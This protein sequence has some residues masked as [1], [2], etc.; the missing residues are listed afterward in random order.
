MVNNIIVILIFVCLGVFFVCL[1]L[2]LIIQSKLMN[3]LADKVKFG[4][5]YFSKGIFP[6][7]TS[8]VAN[9]PSGKLPEWHTSQ[10]ANFP[11]GKLPKWQTSKGT[12]FPSGKLPNWQTS[13]DDNILSCGK[14]PSVQFPKRQLP[15]GPLRHRRL[16]WGPSAEVRMG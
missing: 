11:S 9:F 13:L 8:Q 4:V 15:K 5:R 7:A 14:L 1:F 2:C 3:V 6:R 10:V 16:Q 12:N